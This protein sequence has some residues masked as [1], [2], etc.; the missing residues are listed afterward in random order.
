MSQEDIKIVHKNFVSNKARIIRREGPPAVVMRKIPMAPKKTPVAFG[1][2]E[3]K[4]LPETPENNT[5]DVWVNKTNSEER[6]VIIDRKKGIVQIIEANAFL[7]GI[8]TD[9]W[10]VS[11]VSF[12]AN[13]A[14]E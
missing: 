11:E 13:Y 9:V 7:E 1:M 10:A 5:F 3:V 2:P 6:F 8:P 4:T 14:K 12:D